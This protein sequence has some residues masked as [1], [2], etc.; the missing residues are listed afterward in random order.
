MDMIAL[1]NVYLTSTR[2]SVLKKQNIT[3]IFEAMRRIVNQ[4]NINKKNKNI[5]LHRKIK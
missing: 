2:P 3:N 5:S 4:I 1:G